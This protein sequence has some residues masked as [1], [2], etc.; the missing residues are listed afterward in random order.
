MS[1]QTLRQQARRSARETVARRRLERLEKERR[2]EV[3]AEQGLMA[4][5]ERDAAV[6]VAEQRVGEAVMKLTKDEGLT[7]PEAVEWFDGQV[8]VRE[9]SRL[10]SLVSEAQPG[11]GAEGESGDGSR[12]G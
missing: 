5:A 11:D 12:V 9:A 1:Q 8:S 3:L 10:R 7:L 2:V 6:A 4:L